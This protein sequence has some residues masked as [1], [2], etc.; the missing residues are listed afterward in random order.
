LIDTSY[1]SFACVFCLQEK[2]DEC[3]NAILHLTNANNYGHNKRKYEE[4][5]GSPSGVIDAVFSSDGSND[6]WTVGASSYSTSEP[7]FKKTKNQGQNMNL[8][9][10]NRVIVGILATATSP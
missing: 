5:P 9:P 7:V 1:F 2:V 10:I 3:Y 4:I 8:S 6:S